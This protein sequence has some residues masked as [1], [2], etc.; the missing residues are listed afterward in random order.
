MSAMKLI[1]RLSLAFFISTSINTAVFAASLDTQW[2]DAVYQQETVGDLNKAAQLFTEIIE[3]SDD[4]SVTAMAMVR[5][6][7]CHE[8]LGDA[9]VANALYET[10]KNNYQDIECVSAY[11]EQDN[12]LQASDL[13]AVPWHD[14]EVLEYD[15]YSP[16]DI[17][18]GYTSSV[19]E[20]QNKAGQRIWFTQV[21]F[22]SRTANQ[23][24]HQ[25]YLAYEH[26][27]KLIE[28]SAGRK[29]MRNF[30]ITI[31]NDKVHYKN[32]FMGQDF[33][34]DY[35]PGTFSVTQA[36]DIIRRLPFTD[37]YQTKLKVYYPGNVGYYTL[38]ISVVN[39]DASVEIDDKQYDAWQ[40]HLRLLAATG[41]VFFE[42]QGWIGKT[43][44]RLPLKY[45]SLIN[46][47]VLKSADST[48]A[49]QESVYRIEHRNLE[50]KL[51]IGW[52]AYDVSGRRD[53]SQRIVFM[54]FD[55]T[56]SVVLGWRDDLAFDWDKDPLSKKADESIHW[57]TNFYKAYKVSDGS[58]RQSEYAGMPG[59]RY[60]GEWT[61]NKWTRIEDRVWIKGEEPNWY[62]VVFYTGKNLLETEQPR[63]QRFLD[64]M[65]AY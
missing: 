64:G 18:I 20:L 46:T 43:E 16:D 36:D 35:E 63:F 38:E 47:S 40:I 61:H 22:I 42:Q 39:N 8:Q 62:S 56:S 53:E 31:N 34:F 58:L 48:I 45:A 51:P 17:H 32:Q 50:F 33:S 52:N 15:V 1:Q 5:A 14:G 57:A 26:D 54:P 41:D 13:V 29:D 65:H 19:K 10:L 25:E 59:I 30:E 37:N 2:D 6:A 28:Q 27:S 9:L 11:F 12:N 23:S 55:S 3:Q 44:R 24:T 7:Q 4:R 21:N 49:M 60:L